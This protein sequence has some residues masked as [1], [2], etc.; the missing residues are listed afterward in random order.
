MTDDSNV[1][2][3]PGRERG[4]LINEA[5]MLLLCMKLDPKEAGKAEAVRD[6]IIAIV[7]AWARGKLL[8]RSAAPVLSRIYGDLGI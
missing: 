2:Q 7:K 6:E 3:F 4:Y 5:Q 1:T 8:P